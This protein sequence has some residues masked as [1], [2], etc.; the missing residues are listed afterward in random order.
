VGEQCPLALCR[1]NP[2]VPHPRFPRGRPPPHFPYPK[3]DTLQEATRIVANPTPS[4][5]FPPP[6]FGQPYQGTKGP[7]SAARSCGCSLGPSL[8][9]DLLT[10]RF[11]YACVCGDIMWIVSVCGYVFAWFPRSPGPMCAASGCSLLLPFLLVAPYGR[12]CSGSLLAG[13][14]RSLCS[15]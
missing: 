9:P 8:T 3:G 12:G 6:P 5:P 15:W 14:L 2:L 11:R 10:C 4:P 1:L 13:A 7:T